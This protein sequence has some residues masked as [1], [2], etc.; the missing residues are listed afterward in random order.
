MKF[1]MLFCLLTLLYAVQGICTALPTQFQFRHYNIENG[2]SSNSVTDII[3]DRKGYIWMATDG[4]L[5]CFDGISFTFYQKGNPHYPTLQTN[6][7]HTLCEAGEDTLWL[8]TD[9]GIY[10]YNMK[11]NRIA[12]FDRTTE[13]G[14][15][16]L[17]YINQMRRGLKPVRMRAGVPDYEDAVY[18]DPELFF[19]KIVHERQVEFFA[20]NQRYFDLR[21]WKI[22]P[23]HE[24][25]QIYGCNTLMDEAHRDGFYMPVR[26]ANLQ[27]SFSRKQYFWP[28]HYDELKR[29]QNLTQAPGWQ[30]YD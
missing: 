20:E 13:N 21:R 16:V 3:Q 4:G 26:V 7:I 6:I 22:A 11:E 17:S 2:M 24:G 29:N 30:D 27:T 25:E 23:E 15:S 1:K 5:N 19:E 9:I 28:I 10:I 18:N 8:G 12:R 14:T